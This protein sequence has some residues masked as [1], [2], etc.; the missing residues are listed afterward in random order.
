MYVAAGY[1]L[2]AVCVAVVAMQV[3]STVTAYGVLFRGLVERPLARLVEDVAPGIAA[4]AAVGLVTTPIV[5]ALSGVDAPPVATLGAAVVA[6]A[7]A[8]LLTLRLVS[9]SLWGDLSRLGQ[10]VL[11]GRRAAG[12][13]TPAPL[14]GAE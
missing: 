13:R 6:G 4:A 1:G 11:G 7:I 5:W 14:V 8:G 3:L 2:N 9:R 12:E 10:R